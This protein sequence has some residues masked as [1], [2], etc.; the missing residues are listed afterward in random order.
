M[1]RER[2]SFLMILSLVTIGI[3]FFFENIIKA[4]AN[5]TLLLTILFWSALA[6]GCVALVAAADI[7]RGEWI[8]PLKRELLAFYPMILIVG[9]LFLIFSTK[10][11]SV[12]P[13]TRT[14]GIWLNKEFFVARNAIIIFVNFYLAHLFS[15]ESIADGTKKG[16]FAVLYLFT[17]ILTQS[18]IAFD[19]VMSIEYPWYSTLFGGYTFIESIYSGIAVGG[20]LAVNMLRTDPSSKPYEKVL[21]DI[22]TMTFGF[23]LLWAG[24]FYS[25]FLVIW[26]GNLPEEISFLL[27]RA[28]RTSFKL[29][30]YSVIFLLFVLPFVILLSRKIKKNTRVVFIVASIVLAGIFV[31]RLLYLLPHLSINPI[32]LLIEF[33]AMGL[34]FINLNKNRDLFLR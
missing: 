13:W 5:G 2:P 31:E 19:L 33:I 32:I 14:Q 9:V 21:V 28:E 6:Q 17:F 12:Y 20:I 34:L 24:L 15:K 4:G 22:A 7:A 8:K 16:I 18:L 27:R 3:I 30:G 1:K 29:M 11:D 25:Q 26:Y 10:L 23:S